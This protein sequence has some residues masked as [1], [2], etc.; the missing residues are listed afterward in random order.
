MK[1]FFK[2]FENKL[3][4]FLLILMNAYSTAASFYREEWGWMLFGFFF[5][6]YFAWELK[7]LVFPSNQEQ[8]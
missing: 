8:T 3:F 5:T 4:I 1:L 6:C 7:S 2:L